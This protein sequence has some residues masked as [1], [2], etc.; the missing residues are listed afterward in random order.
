MVQ[1]TKFTNLAR[2][3]FLQTIGAGIGGSWLAPVLDTTVISPAAAGE[4]ALPDKRQA[5]YMLRRVLPLWKP[6]EIIDETLN[7]CETAAIGEIIW[8]VDVT[9]FNHGFTPHDI[10]RHI[11]PGWKRRAT[12]PVNETSAFPSTPGSPLDT[13]PWDPIL[14]VL[15][16]DFI[17]ASCL[18]AVQCRNAPVLLVPV[19]APGF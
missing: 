2:R 18:V 19:G 6:K 9:A 15:P 5:Q 8:K 1:Q 4:N 16:R 14:T 7:F 12:I 10:I 11:Y 3:H 13:C 17:G